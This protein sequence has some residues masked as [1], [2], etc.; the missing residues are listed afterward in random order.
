VGRETSTV[1]AWLLAV[2]PL[3]VYF[4][5]YARPYSIALLLSFL[6]LFALPSW[7]LRG[8]RVWLW[9][10]VGAATLGPYFHLTAL[11]V[12]LLP[13]A[14]A[15]AARLAGPRGAGLS[16]PVRTL[17]IVTVAVGIGLLALLGPPLLV[18]HRA[19][20]YKTARGEVHA[21]MLVGA[22]SLVAGSGRTGVVAGLGLAALGGGVALGR[23]HPARVAFLAAVA[24]FAVGL[25]LVTHP[26]LVELPMVFVRYAL[27]LLPLALL[28]VAGGV[29]S[30][31]ALVGPRGPK[32]AS[33]LGPGLAA[34]LVWL[35]P[36]PRTHRHPNAWT[37]H[38]AFQYSYTTPPCDPGFVPPPFYER[39]AREPKGSQ[40]LLEAPWLFAATGNNLFL[41]DQGV[42]RQ[43][44][45]I[46]FVGGVF[47]GAGTSGLP[48]PGE[49]PILAQPRRYR[50]R[51]FVHLGNPQDVRSSGAT[52]VVLH[53]TIEKEMTGAATA[54]GLGIEP[55]LE[56]YR[57]TFGP[58][59]YEDDW[60]AVFGV[61]R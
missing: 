39:L 12:V 20:L 53:K 4:S 22:A 7:R 6:A 41:C 50:F 45:R 59:V 56:R 5:R 19:L 18:D 55:W 42:H 38:P 2:S 14:I 16:L 48:R 28:L 17:S 15:W 27:V 26:V 51:S 1:F 29:M 3:H 32:A 49:L 40:R 35:G 10:Y 37:N 61:A 25:P 52:L 21:A 34:L 60:M 11:P 13:L 47:D 44:M 57:G 8:E 33:V 24:V 31:L 36:L 23:R 46:G 30:S 43:E 54:S 9:V 58:P